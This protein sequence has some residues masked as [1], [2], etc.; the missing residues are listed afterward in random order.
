MKI[1]QKKFKIVN[2]KT[3]YIKGIF[4]YSFYKVLNHYYIMHIYKNNK[5][6]KLFTLRNN[7]YRISEYKPYNRYYSKSKLYIPKQRE[8]EIYKY[9]KDQYILNIEIIENM[10][11]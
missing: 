11:N 10:I 5:P 9:L 1:H 3:I 2:N 4:T 8:K 6:Y 7:L